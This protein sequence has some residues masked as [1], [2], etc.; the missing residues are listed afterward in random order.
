[1]YA[2]ARPVGTSV[3]NDGSS[4]RGSDSSRESMI[5]WRSP[6]PPEPPQASAM[7]TSIPSAARGAVGPTRQRT[8]A[9]GEYGMFP[10]PLTLENAGENLRKF[11]VMRQSKSARRS[12]RRAGA[13]CVATFAIIDV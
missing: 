2:T 1:M 13:S 12:D 6:P 4:D 3:D 5:V 9:A 8:S 10:P 7:A 11:A